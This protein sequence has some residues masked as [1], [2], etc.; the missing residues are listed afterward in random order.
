MN[1]IAVILE[2]WAAE[3]NSLSK[4]AAKTA[5]R[6]IQRAVCNCPGALA[7]AR[8]GFLHVD[9]AA[10]DDVAGPGRKAAPFR[11]QRLPP[12]GRGMRMTGTTTASD[13]T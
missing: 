3:A 8:V 4:T 12:G 10:S 7:L 5:Y 1:G 9:V 13:A 6:F 2:N 11:A